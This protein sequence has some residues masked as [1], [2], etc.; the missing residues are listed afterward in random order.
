MAMLNF[1]LKMKNNSKVENKILEMK[2]KKESMKMKRSISSLLLSNEI[3]LERKID[4]S[5][6]NNIKVNEK[7]N[8]KINF[9]NAKNNIRKKLIRNS[10]E[11][12]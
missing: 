2:N 10:S 7:N 8:N 4:N 9:I 12:F 11:I 1:Q 3:K 5:I 6:N